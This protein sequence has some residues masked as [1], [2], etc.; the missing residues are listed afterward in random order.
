MV[1]QKELRN[2]LKTNNIKLAGIVET[3][4]KKHNPSRISS[5]IAPGWDVMQNYSHAVNGWIWILWDSNYYT[6]TLI[7]TEAQIPNV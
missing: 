2:C 3:R 7:R 5:H 4:V 6:V 1:K